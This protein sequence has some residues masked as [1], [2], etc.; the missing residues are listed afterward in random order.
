MAELI[1][2]G[3]ALSQLDAIAAYIALDKPDAAK[4]VVRRVIELTDQVQKFTK[5]G[6]PIPELRHPNYRQVWILPC[7]VYYRTEGDR[8]FVLHVRRAERPL[9]LDD[10]IAAGEKPH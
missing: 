1:W 6:R 9:R 2:T 3:P 10:L 5:L 7:W 8:V 4:A